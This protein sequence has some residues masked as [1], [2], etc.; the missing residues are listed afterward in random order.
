MPYFNPNSRILFCCTPIVFLEGNLSTI[1]CIFFLL[2]YFLILTCLIFVQAITTL[3]KIKVFIKESSLSFVVIP[4]IMILNCYPQYH[5]FISFVSLCV[6]FIIGVHQLPIPAKTSSF[7]FVKLK[8]LIYK[9]RSWPLGVRIVLLIITMCLS[10]YFVRNIFFLISTFL[11]SLEFLF[12]FHPYFFLRILIS[13]L[14]LLNFFKVCFV[15]LISCRLTIHTMSFLI[16]LSL[17]IIIFTHRSLVVRLIANFCGTIIRFLVTGVIER[18]VIVESSL[19][20]GRG[21]FVMAGAGGG[22]TSLP[23][24][25]NAIP[26]IP[27]PTDVAK[28]TKGHNFFCKTNF[29]D[30]VI[31]RTQE[32]YPLEYKPSYSRLFYKSIYL[33]GTPQS[34]HNDVSVVNNFKLNM[35]SAFTS[36][37]FLQD[38]VLRYYGIPTSNIDYRRDAFFRFWLNRPL[39]PFEITS[40]ANICEYNCNKEIAL[41]VTGVHE[42]FGKPVARTF[43]RCYGS[44]DGVITINN[45]RR[46]VD[47][48]SPLTDQPIQE[49]LDKKLMN[50]D[51]VVV[52]NNIDDFSSY[53][54]DRIIGVKPNS[55]NYIPAIRNINGEIERFKHD[56][57]NPFIIQTGIDHLTITTNALTKFLKK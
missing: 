7:E 55:I 57:N 42:R 38:E 48:Y 15:D 29:P 8:E 41:T 5:L 6:L 32:K 33:E 28:I 30:R 36:L 49:I 22:I 44:H 23:N 9:L 56:R 11:L 27:K 21:K 17:L 35:G 3:L 50:I 1:E 52:N 40:M 12:E 19:L 25:T 13:L 51:Y 53:S 46:T 14:F 24:E 31:V 43:E 26:T 47:C 45:Q 39:F 20:F 16:C 54:T 37:R 18:N 2:G 34:L 10:I 4:F